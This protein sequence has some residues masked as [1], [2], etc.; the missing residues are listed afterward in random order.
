MYGPPAPLRDDVRVSMQD[1][2][3]VADVGDKEA[4][5]VRA[6]AVSA[7]GAASS[8]DGADGNGASSSK[9]PSDR[10]PTQTGGAD[11]SKALNL[12]FQP[13]TL[14]FNDLHYFVPNPKGEGELELLRGA[15]GVFRPGVL[16]AL[17]GASGAGKTTLMDVL[18]DRKTAGRMTGAV[19]VNGHDKEPHSFAR[20]MGTL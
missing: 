15:Y 18:A 10:K 16:T 12:P 5:G 11:G 6:H 17:M 1:G 19:K 2:A 4:H 7:A 9:S 20:I 13:V 3:D 14:T 8:D